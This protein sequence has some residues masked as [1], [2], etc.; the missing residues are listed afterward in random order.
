MLVNDPNECV[1]EIVRRV[2]CKIILATPLGIGKPVQLLNFLYQ[3]AKQDSSIEL[4][5]FTALTFLKP[6]F[7]Q[8][9]VKKIFNPYLQ[10]IYGDYQDLLY[11]ID[12]RAN[13]LP[14]NVKVVE[15]FLSAGAYLQNS[16]V[17]KNFIASNYTHVVRD[18]LSYGINV[19]AQMIAC[20][21]GDDLRFSLS[22]NAD[23]TNDFLQKMPNVLFVGQV[24]RHLPYMFGPQVEIAADRF[25]IVLQYEAGHKKIFSIPKQALDEQEYAIG[26]YVSS[27]I[28]DDGCLQIGIGNMSDAVVYSL[29]LRHTQNE[30][31]KNLLG[32]LAVENLCEPFDIGLFALTEML[33]DGY[34]D[35]YN[36]G[37]LKKK[38]HDQSGSHLVH[39]GFFVGSNAFYEKLRKMSPKERRYFSMRGINEINQLYGDEA[40]RRTQRKNARFVNS[41][42]K[43][44]LLGEILSDSL[45][46]GLTISGVGGQ[47]NFVAMAHEIKDARSIIICRSVREKNCKLES[48]IL[49]K[50]TATIPRHLRDLVVTEYGIADLRGK[51]D[52]EVIKAMLNVTDS[53]F[54]EPLLLEAKS[55]KKISPTYQIP[56]YYKNNLPGTITKRLKKYKAM[57]L[58]VDFPLGNEFNQDEIILGK[59]LKNLK[60]RSVL[61]KFFMALCGFFSAPNLQQSA[62]L[63]K[64][65]L[66]KPK[67]LKDHC[68]R[69][70]FLGEI[71]KHE[72]C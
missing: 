62:L 44:T 19:F 27:L 14:D 58:L 25:D 5:I 42:L 45:E 10:R 34:L 31:Y 60:S 54:Q 2:G 9:L 56:N 3:R 4:T 64:I 50:C 52:E 53:R 17:Q 15:F 59:A 35:L 23:L 69:A 55:A 36:N 70:M 49:F 8:K 68:Y 20:R 16:N 67:G 63:Q 7:Q 24:N 32:D 33:V 41:C 61:G 39:A 71:K 38:I 43:A 18:S 22:S 21:S 26:L 40:T 13:N 28:K 30:N 72:N 1:N 37:I 46:N 12:R 51:T 29:I 66:D 6:S 47:Y 11:E 48:N 57:G 65:E